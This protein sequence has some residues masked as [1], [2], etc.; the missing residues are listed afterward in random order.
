M[1]CGKYPNKQT[2]LSKNKAEKEV[3]KRRKVGKLYIF[4]CDY[5][6]NYHLTSMWQIK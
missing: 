4:K 5:C 2:F 3:W 6:H 1:K